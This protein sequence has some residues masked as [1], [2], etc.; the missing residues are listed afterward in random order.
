MVNMINTAKC[1]CKTLFE[2]AGKSAG[3]YK[4]AGTPRLFSIHKDP[5]IGTEIRN[6]ISGTRYFSRN[7]LVSREAEMSPLVTVHRADGSYSSM[8]AES[9]NNLYAQLKRDPKAWNPVIKSDPRIGKELFVNNPICAGR[10][11]RSA[12]S[13]DGNLI[14]KIESNGHYQSMRPEEFD[15]MIL[16]LLG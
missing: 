9:F 10:Y 11:F 13:P 3:K 7:G 14:T 2:S 16:N 1:A 15:N 8:P 12:A 5:A 4:M 6:N